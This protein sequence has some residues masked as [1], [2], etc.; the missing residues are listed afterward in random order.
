MTFRG[1]PTFDG[2][3]IESDRRSRDLP[4][5]R[6]RRNSG[7]NQPF[8]EGNGAGKG[9]LHSGCL[10]GRAGAAQH[11]AAACPITRTSSLMRDGD[12]SDFFDGRQIDDAV[13]ETSKKVAPPLA[14][15][16]DANFGVVQNDVHC[17]FKF[18]YERECKLDICPRRVKGCRV[19]Q[20]GKRRGNN[21]Q[22]HLSA[23]RT[24][25]S[26]SAIGMS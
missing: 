10:V 7:R 14:S 21:D 26:A 24:C 13:G 4:E 8:W 9:P 6:P 3:R 25:A 2:R 11:L 15:K 17:S 20:L 23:A 5:R 18:A 1:K 19:T 16:H 22:F 12:N